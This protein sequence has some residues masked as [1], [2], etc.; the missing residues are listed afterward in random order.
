G[1]HDAADVLV[2]IHHRILPGDDVL[3]AGQRD[4]AEQGADPGHGVVDAVI[5][6][7]DIEPVDDDDMALRIEPVKLGFFATGGAGGPLAGVGGGGAG[8]GGG[9]GAA[10]FAAGAGF[11]AAA[12]W[13]PAAGD[14]TR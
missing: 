1:R 9:G 11:A 4:V 13:L 10:G 14:L 2:Q 8:C 6:A 3:I 12:G 7:A 5:A